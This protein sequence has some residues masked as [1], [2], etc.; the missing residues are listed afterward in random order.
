VRG[1]SNLNFS[2]SEGH[3]LQILERMPCFNLELN[4]VLPTSAQ[5]DAT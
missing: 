3:A 1:V 5:F 2:K 4:K